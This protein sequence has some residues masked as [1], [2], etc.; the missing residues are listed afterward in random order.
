MKTLFLCFLGTLCAGS[1]AAIPA[2][3]PNARLTPADSLA[4]VSAVQAKTPESLPAF[5]PSITFGGYL[6]SKFEVTDRQG[7]STASNFSMRYLRLYGSGYVWRDVFYR[8]QL[9]MSGAP[10]VDRGPRLLDAYVESR[11][12]PEIQVRIGQFHRPFGFDKPLSPLAVGLG[13]FS[14][15]ASKLQSLN[16]RIGEHTSNGRDA[17]VQIMGDLLPLSSG[18]KFLHYQVGLFNGQGINHADIDHFKDLI[19]GL[20]VC[21]IDGLSVGGF[22]WNGRFTD[23]ANPTHRLERKRYALGFKYEGRWDARG[24]YVHSH[25]STTKG[26]ALART[27]NQLGILLQLPS[28]QKLSVPAQLHPHARSSRSRSRLQHFRRAILGTFLISFD[29][30]NGLADCSPCFWVSRAP[31]PFPFPLPKTRKK[32]TA[33][34]S[35]RYI[36]VE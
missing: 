35:S 21:P 33:R 6:T 29:T 25:G 24:E 22:G 15:V 8:F 18:R 5:K 3:T 9:E 11:K 23:P 7:A 20:W 28:G 34:E 16:D 31:Q 19:G 17:G 2:E 36:G 12:Y 27:E 13:S 10:G 30:E 1:A 4:H 32:L 26:G 14:Q